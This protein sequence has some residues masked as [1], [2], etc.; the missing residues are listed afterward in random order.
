MKTPSVVVLLTATAISLAWGCSTV[1]ERLGIE[2]EQPPEQFGTPDAGPDATPD[3]RELTAYCP[4]SQCPP[5]WTTCPDS[6]FP[7]DT[8][9]LADS[10]NC[11]GCG[12]ACPLGTGFEQFTCN[13]GACKLECNAAL[14][15]KDCD[16]LVDNG[17]ESSQLDPA[18]CGACGVACA[19]GESCRWQDDKLFAP[20]TP[21]APLATMLAIRPEGRAL[22]SI[23]T[24]TTA[25]S[26]ASAASP[27]ANPA[28]P[29][30]MESSRTAARRR[31]AR[32]TTAGI[33]ATRVGQGRS[34]P[35]TA[36]ADCRACAIQA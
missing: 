31:S 12:M 18:N 15:S 30:A 10:R 6:R 36:T 1:D 29:T 14:R 34:A 23:R 20:T 7:C 9:I 11:G 22:R 3:P 24:C 8:N 33:A 26:Q 2:I 27:S 13:E 32:T 28:S 5:G 4:S 16:G 19:V 21:I 35:P 25:A 17:C